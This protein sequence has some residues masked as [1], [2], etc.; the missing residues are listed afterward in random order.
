MGGTGVTMGGD[1]YHGN[2][3]P[4]SVFSWELNFTQ[5]WVEMRIWAFPGSDFTHS[6]GRVSSERGRTLSGRL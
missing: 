4:T 3:E 2:Q 6:F 1:S 5:W